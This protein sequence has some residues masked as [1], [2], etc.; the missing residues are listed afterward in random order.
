[1]VSIS[2]IME[3]PLNH[4]NPRVLRNEIVINEYPFSPPFE[5][6]LDVL[7]KANFAKELDGTQ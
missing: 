7:K 5:G 4:P 1:M 6:F 2:L 3:S